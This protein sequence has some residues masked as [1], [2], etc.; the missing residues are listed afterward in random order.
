[1]CESS[2]LITERLQ[3]IVSAVHC[4]AETERTE[5]MKERDDKLES[6]STKVK[7]LK[8]S[9]KERNRVV[10]ELEKRLSEQNAALEASKSRVTE[11][12]ASAAELQTR[13]AELRQTV[14][15]RDDQIQTLRDELTV[16]CLF[17]SL[18]LYVCLLLSVCIF[19]IL[20]RFLF[21]AKLGKPE[22]S[23][24]VHTVHIFQPHFGYWFVSLILII[25]IIFKL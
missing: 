11:T 25:I 4:R 23:K 15:E 3:Y 22:Y 10:E 14:S 9:L 24:R 8:T 2:Q 1:V 13:L 7:E 17:V 20:F 19:V 21:V 16:V 5:W 6:L 18:C 12:E